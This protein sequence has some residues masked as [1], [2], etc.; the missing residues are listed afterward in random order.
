MS[1]VPAEDEEDRLR[2]LGVVAQ[3]SRTVEVLINALYA[4]VVRIRW[5]RLG[6]PNP[7]EQ[8]AIDRFRRGVADLDAGLSDADVTDQ[9]AAATRRIAQLAQTRDPRTFFSWDVIQR[10][11]AATLNPAGWGYLR[12]LRAQSDYRSVWK[13]ALPVP[14]TGRPATLPFAPR[15]TTN[16]LSHSRHLA[17]F[18]DVTGRSVADLDLIVEFGGGFGGMEHLAR[19]HGFTGRYVIIDL[20]IVRELQNFYLSIEGAREVIEGLTDIPKG[21]DPPTHLIGLDS[22]DELRPIVT[23]ASD[24]LF[25]ATWSLSESPLEVRQRIFEL[26]P[27]FPLI[28]VAYQRSFGRIDNM[29]LAKE[30]AAH[31]DASM[32]W[33]HRPIVVFRRERNNPV[34]HYAIGQRT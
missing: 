24:A 12:T 10:T 27:E 19:T 13:S 25:M 34:S 29:V 30:L 26:L 4:T 32:Q 20:P 21:T 28:L 8:R 2:R 3:R 11:I 15:T 5:G 23:A 1:E 18:R 33:E 31:A 22:L 6:A 14:S 17:I 7:D 16:R 9:W